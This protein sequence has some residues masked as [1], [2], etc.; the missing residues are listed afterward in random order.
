MSNGWDY[1]NQSFCFRGNRTIR[2]GVDYLSAFVWFAPVVWLW[3]FRR[4]DK[5]KWYL[6]LGICGLRMNIYW[7]PYFGERARH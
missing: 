3:Q 2:V 4:I 6:L 7:D 5:D 1:W